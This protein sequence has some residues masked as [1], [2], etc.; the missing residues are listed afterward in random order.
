MGGFLGAGLMGM[1]FGGSFSGGALGGAGSSILQLLLIGGLVYFLFRVLGTR[2]DRTASGV[3]DTDYF[4][5]RAA[6]LPG[7]TLARLLPVQGVA[8][9]PV[10]SLMPALAGPLVEAGSLT[11][12][13][14]A[15][16]ESL[17][18][19]VQAAY[20]RGDLSRLRTLVSPEMLGH[21][22]ES[23]SANASHGVEN[24]VEAVKLEQGELSEAWSEAGL[25]YASVALRY[26]MLDV[27]RS[28]ADGA[29]VAG[30]D[31]DRTEATEVWT[32]LRSPGGKWIV[33]AIQ[34]AS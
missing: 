6:P 20:S 23:L 9:S 34:Q 32:Y 29:V 11:D 26:S 16:F 3:H 22:S 28:V 15:S 5:D 33:S 21:F 1:I 24:K 27:T 4:G 19:E 17:L 8:T 2:A 14:R 30:S 13:D 12:A 18:S 31:S 7:V 25:D 10:R